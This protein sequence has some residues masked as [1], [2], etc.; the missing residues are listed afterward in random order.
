MAVGL[1]V[2]H[3]GYTRGLEAAGKATRGF[4]GIIEH[5]GI[6]LSQFGS[7]LGG[8]SLAVLFREAAQTAD[9][10]SK[11]SRAVGVTTEQLAGLN[12]GA[13]LSGVSAEQLRTSLVRLNDT[14]DQAGQGSSVAVTAFQRLGISAEMLADLDT[15]QTLEL[16]AD[17]MSKLDGSSAKAGV[18]LDL[19]GRSGIGMV[20]VLSGGSEGLKQFQRDAESLGLSITSTGGRGIE[21]MNDSLSLLKMSLV[22]TATQIL[23]D[24][25][26]AIVTMAKGL[27]SLLTVIKDVLSNPIAPALLVIVTIGPKVV[28]AIMTIV[29]AI[30][31]LITTQTIAQAFSGPAGW[32]ALAAGAGVA[33]AALYGVTKLQDA[34]NDSLGETK[35]QLDRVT[36]AMGEMDEA[37]IKTLKEQS[38]LL[39]Q[40]RE[41][42]RNFGKSAEEVKLQAA[43]N[44]VSGLSE[45]YRN[46][47]RDASENLK[48]LESQD[49]AAKRGL[50]LLSQIE[51]ANAD[52]FHKKIISIRRDLEFAGAT[53]EQT[54]SIIRKM[55]SEFYAK[56][57]PPN[58]LRDWVNSGVT[59]AIDDQHAA[60]LRL[61]EAMSQ[62]MPTS[63]VAIL[64][65]YESAT[66]ALQQAE[67]DGIITHEL[68][69]QALAKQEKLTADA[70]RK[71]AQDI[72]DMI[73]TPQE[74]MAEFIRELETLKLKKLIDEDQFEKARK[75]MEE[76]LGLA[77]DRAEVEKRIN[78]LPQNQAIRMGTSEAFA[79]EFRLNFG[80]DKNAE[81]NKVEKDQLSVQEKTY[82]SI[83]RIRKDGL[84]EVTEVNI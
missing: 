20:E 22:G 29:K 52:E 38:E 45:E 6:S 41:K 47:L 23:Q 76:M 68:Y 14:I 42:I 9:A 19:F 66:R 26:P 62:P 64:E 84:V 77:K 80:D 59:Q 43:L 54:D 13:E 36:G 78:E 50:A 46:S 56:T 57:A 35:D 48:V 74:R 37:A 11:T 27:R 4:R 39:E 12:V 15:Y 53:A 44:N 21:S 73:R 30:R 10:L 25:A 63:A 70:L 61:T 55:W 40:Y 2:N 5:A 7:L 60:L 69:L 28:A 31:A 34:F 17:G 3:A 75:K 65:H 71:R 16:I 81:K 58:P 33:A 83:E 82:R 67:H 24:F 49:E 32:A 8:I 18:A 51:P 72:L 79:N 1:S